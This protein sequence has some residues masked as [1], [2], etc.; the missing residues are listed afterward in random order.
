MS[1]KIL[2]VDDSV[3]WIC[4]IREIIELSFPNTFNLKYASSAKEA[5]EIVAKFKPD[6]IITDL[7]M[8]KIKNNMYAGEYLIKTVKNKFSEIK[9]II[10]SGAVEIDKI[11]ARNNVEGYIAKWS[12]L[13]YPINLKLKISEIFNIQT[14]IC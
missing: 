13:D 11:A 4:S 5:L 14:E 2:I 12:F 7:E 9:V 10:I 3:D 8:E 1:A 6:L